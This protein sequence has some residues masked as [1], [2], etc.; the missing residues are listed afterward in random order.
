MTLQKIKSTD[1]K[2][3]CGEQIRWVS[4]VD[5]GWRIPKEITVTLSGQDCRFEWFIFVIG[6]DNSAFPLDMKVIHK[7]P[8]TVSYISARAVLE[9]ESQIEWNARA[10]VERGAAGADTYLSF[11]TLL[12]SPGAR[13]KTI[14]SLEIATDD[15]T[16]GHAASVDRL[17]DEALHYCA[18]R[19]LD[20][21]ETKKLLARAFLNADAT[22]SVAHLLDNIW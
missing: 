4:V 3:S 17:A 8:N 10:I 5:R 14:P 7:A 19:G 2:V 15:V 11:R 6:R 18:T 12:L 22:E 21:S 13:A 1:L 16:A 9:G 20:Q